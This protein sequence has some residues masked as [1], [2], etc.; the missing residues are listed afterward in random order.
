MDI[1]YELCDSIQLKLHIQMI[2]PLAYVNFRK[3]ENIM[4][5]IKQNKNFTLLNIYIKLKVYVH[6]ANIHNI[7]VLYI[8]SIKVRLKF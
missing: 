8:N 2:L 6:I 1:C 3:I 7:S 4:I 5:H